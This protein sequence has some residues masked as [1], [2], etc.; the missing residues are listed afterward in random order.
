MC[1]ARVR[2]NQWRTEDVFDDA[3]EAMSLFETAGEVDLAIDAA[4]LG[5]AFASRLGELALAAELA[6]RAIIGQDAVTDDRLRAEIANRLG[7]FCY[8]F[9]DYERAVEQFEASLAAAE[10][11]PSPD[12]V[13]RQLHN[14]ADALLLAWRQR[15]TAHLEPPPEWLDRAEEAVRRLLAEGTAEIHRRTGCHRLTA[16][17][18]CERG[19]HEEALGL[20]EEFRSQTAAI[21]QE[22]QRAAL[23]L[24]EGR[25]LRL[26]GRADE[27]VALVRRAVQFAEASG[28]DHE[29]MLALEELAACEAAA[30]DFPAALETAMEVKARMWAIHQRQTRHLVQEVWDRA[31]IERDRDD[32]QAQAAKSARSAEQDELTGAGNR[33]L[34]ERFLDESSAHQTNVI[35]IM[36]DVDHF[37]EINDTQ[38]HHTGDAVLRRLSQLLVGELRAGQAAVRYGGDE[39]VLALPG[40]GLKAAIGFAERLRL[41]VLGHDWAALAPDLHVSVSI[42]VAEGLISNSQRVIAAA[43]AQL[44]TAKH[45]GRNRV[46]GASTENLHGLVEAL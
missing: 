5:A 30:G 34:L 33:R 43:D 46:A 6:T 20:L 13:C 36:V 16:E 42:G 29:L 1:R 3:R 37:K 22:A 7:I 41:A 19:R 31:E 40:I 12:K 4:S 44:Y 26:A 32:F 11:V 8:S 45:L 27:A 25:C 35:I 24:V 21:S 14:I 39:F 23:A 28:D 2:S 9:L 10:R 38:G 15:R 18:L 17:I